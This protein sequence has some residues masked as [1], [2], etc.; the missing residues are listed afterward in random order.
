MSQSPHQIGRSRSDEYPSACELGD[1]C[2][3]GAAAAMVGV[4]METD[5][6]AAGLIFTATPDEHPRP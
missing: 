5:A 1:P 2:R 3:D 6:I 4:E